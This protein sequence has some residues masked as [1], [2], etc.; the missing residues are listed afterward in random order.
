M[1]LSEQKRK[2]ARNLFMSPP[3]RLSQS[4]QLYP[5]TSRFCLKE[6]S[7]IFQVNL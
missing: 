1:K 4:R 6:H 5:S 3:S 7:R 2:E